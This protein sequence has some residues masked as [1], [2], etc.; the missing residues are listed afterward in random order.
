MAEP[1]SLWKGAL[2]GL[3]VAII[4][5]LAVRWLALTVL[6]VPAEFPPLAAP[7]PTIFFTAIGTLGAAGVFAIVRRR[8]ENPVSAFR[9]IAIV[10]LILSFLPDLWLLSD[11]GS[12]A[13]PGAT[14]TGVGVLMV[15][16]TVAA[17]TI[18]WGLTGPFRTEARISNSAGDS[19]PG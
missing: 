12:G 19:W 9:R 17:L 5:T 10:T 2:K 15:L 3:V 18:V 7:F 6:S 13:F 8:A 14:P 4:S 11:G 1:S 16:H